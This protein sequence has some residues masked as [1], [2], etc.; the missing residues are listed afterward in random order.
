MNSRQRFLNALSQQPLDRPPVWIM[1]QAG[2]YLPEYRK[3]KEQYSFLEM[4]KS[5]ELAEEVTLQPLRRYALDAAIIFSDILVI[6]EALGVPYSFRDQG[7][8]QIDKQITSR[9]MIDEL[10]IGDITEKLGYVMAALKRVRASIGEEKTLLGFGGSPWTLAAYMLEG[11]SSQN[12]HT[13]KSFFVEERAAYDALME[14]I[15]EATI[16]YFNAQADAGVDAIQIFDSWGAACPG[17]WYQEM[18]LKWIQKIIKGLN[19]RVPIIVYAKGMSHHA[20]RIADTGAGAISVDWSVDLPELKSQLGSRLAVQGNL[21]PA[22]L[23]T[24]PELTRMAAQEILESMRGHKGFVFNL[25]HGIHPTAKTD[26][27]AALIE[28]VTQFS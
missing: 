3:L 2:R 7:G 23:D 18:S 13:A 9:A 19:G 11:G 1:R 5:P 8:I 14:K 16:T 12:W 20:M 21:D 24:T 25:G 22:I 28:T 17:T 15:A 27:M 4:V 10:E 6:P 26:N